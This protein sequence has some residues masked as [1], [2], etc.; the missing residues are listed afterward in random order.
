VRGQ[1][2]KKYDVKGFKPTSSHASLKAVVRKR[3]IRKLVSLSL[4]WALTEFLPCMEE[5]L[6]NFKKRLKML[7]QNADAAFPRQPI[8]PAW[9]TLI[10]TFLSVEK[11]IGAYPY[12]IYN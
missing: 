2:P 11:R 8:S 6:P 4:P 3:R 9:E 5:I 10:R 12:L 7:F 1:G